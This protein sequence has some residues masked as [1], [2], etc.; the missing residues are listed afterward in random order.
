MRAS[1]GLCCECSCRRDISVHTRDHLL[2]PDLLVT[3]LIRPGET[4]VI[5]I[6]ETYFDRIT[7]AKLQDMISQ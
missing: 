1:T 2:L 4:K 3:V 6:I 5:I 7:H